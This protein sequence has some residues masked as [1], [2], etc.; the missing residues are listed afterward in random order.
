V[1]GFHILFLRK[2]YYPLF[3][4]CPPFSHLTSCTPT[5]S[6]LYLANSL[7]AAVSV[8][9]LYRL[10]TYY[11]PNL[12][13]LFRSLGC[14]KVSIRVRGMCSCFV[15]KPVFMGRSGQNLAQ[16]QAGVLPLVGYPQLLIQYIC[17]YPPYWRLFLHPWPEDVPC[18]GD[19]DTFIMEK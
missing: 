10:L 19:R 13:F 12:M 6:N 8:P 17:S 14:T 5:K 15:S 16:P 4:L 3:L 2:K 9:A 18:L 7:A 11:I 1:D